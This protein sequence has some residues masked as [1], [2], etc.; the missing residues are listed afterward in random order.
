MSVYISFF[1]LAHNQYIIKMIFLK[2]TLIYYFLFCKADNGVDSI[3]SNS[4]SLLVQSSIEWFSSVFITKISE[5][6]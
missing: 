2:K 6:K 4:F 5:L 1:S 3:C